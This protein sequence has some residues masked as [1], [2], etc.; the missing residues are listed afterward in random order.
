MRISDWSSDVCS[1]DLFLA[2]FGQVVR[3]QK[4]AVGTGFLRGLR[5]FDG[6]AGGAAR[7]G[8]NG[9]LVTARVDGRLDDGRV[10]AAGQRKEFA[11][12]AGGKERRGAVR[13]QSG[14]AACRERGGQYV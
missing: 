13:Y 9:H 5:A 4:H 1:S 12:A 8:N 7:P 3:Q 11:G 14:R 6:E 10:F 2:G